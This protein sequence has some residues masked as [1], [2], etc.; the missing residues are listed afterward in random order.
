MVLED[1]EIRELEPEEVS[2]LLSYV[3]R[4]AGVAVMDGPPKFRVLR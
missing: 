1:R 4:S 3:R 2:L